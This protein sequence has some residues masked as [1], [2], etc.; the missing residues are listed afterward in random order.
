[1]NTKCFM[2]YTTIFTKI[3]LYTFIYTLTFHHNSEEESHTKGIKMFHVSPCDK[4]YTSCTVLKDIERKRLLARHS[5]SELHQAMGTVLGFVLMLT[6]E[7]KNWRH[8]ILSPQLCLTNFRNHL[9]CSLQSL[10][11]IGCL[12]TLLSHILRFR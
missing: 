10:Q 4:N 5:A 7:K 9:T 2:T 6:A 11:H 12:G 3:F 8:D 1:M